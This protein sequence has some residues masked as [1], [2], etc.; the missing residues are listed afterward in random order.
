MRGRRLDARSGF[1]WGTAFVGSAVGAPGML[2]VA[3]DSSGSSIGRPVGPVTGSSV[4]RTLT[5]GTTDAHADARVVRLNCAEAIGV[6][7]EVSDVDEPILGALALPTRRAFDRLAG[8]LVLLYG[9]PS[10]ASAE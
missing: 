9:R 8:L 10:P 6:S 5:A 3:C 1:I 7:A 2:I 4:S